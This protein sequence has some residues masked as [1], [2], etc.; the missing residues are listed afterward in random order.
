MLAAV[1]RGPFTPARGSFSGARLRDRLSLLDRNLADIDRHLRALAVA[2]A[3]QHRA[4]PD[5]LHQL[6][7]EIACRRAADY[8]PSDGSFLTFVYTRVRFALHEACQREARERRL[9]R[10]LRGALQAIAENLEQ[11]D[12]DREV[13][14][15]IPA[16]A[17]RDPHC[18]RARMAMTA[19]AIVA[20]FAIPETPETLL[21]H[22]QDTALLHHRVHAALAELAPRDRDLVL[23]TTVDRRS[24]A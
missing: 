14:D 23:K 11:D 2:I 5:D 24:L 15:S 9:K 19:A 10:A 20:T 8:R 17:I 6:A 1:L 3:R 18:T 4:D 22:A 7:L 12:P 21:A 16:A 13:R